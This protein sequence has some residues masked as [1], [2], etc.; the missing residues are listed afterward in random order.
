MS[1]VFKERY[2][3]VAF[4]LDGVIVDSEAAHMNI[5]VNI[6]SE[7]GTSIHADQYKTF[8][9]KSDYEITKMIV[10]SKSLPISREELQNRYKQGLAD[11]LDAG[12]LPVVEGVRELIRMLHEEG[13]RLAV[14]SSSSRMNI[15]KSLAGAG[16][17]EYFD[18]IVSAEDVQN[19]KPA[20]DIYLESVRKMG[21]Q[22]HECAAIEDAHYGALSAKRAGL[23]TVGFHNPNSGDQ[24]LSIAD[25]VVD[26]MA[27]LY[28]R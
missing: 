24:N 21:L 17:R 2:L 7:F 13:I 14:A 3:G 23:Y 8:V 6:L 28:D 22:P 26:S 27:Q 19:G 20:P 25:I 16:V 5:Y 10:E 11:W 1:T 12:D 4:D 18:T 9:G 15:E